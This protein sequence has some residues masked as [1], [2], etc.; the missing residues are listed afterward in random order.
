MPIF[1]YRVLNG[2]NPEHFI[3][4][5]QSLKEP[6]LDLHPIT[7]EKIERV[8]KSSSLILKHA[9]RIE[10]QKLNPK[11]LE[12][13]GFSLYERAGEGNNFQRTVGHTG[14][15]SISPSG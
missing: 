4:V 8:V 7:K 5:E 15:K 3:E 10:R 11:N 6:A 1:R 14:P 12:K 2:K 13:N 9:D